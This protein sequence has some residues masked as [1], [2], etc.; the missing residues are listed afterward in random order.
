M[1]SLRLGLMM[2]VVVV[3]A[4]G[5]AHPMTMRADIAG[6]ALPAG[7]TPIPKN[8]GLYISP[9]N[10]AKEVTTPGGGG[11]K[12]SYHPYADMETGLYKI[13]GETFQNVD[14]L[15]TL[16]DVN[17]I[18]KHSLTLIAIP[19]ITTTSSSSGFFTWMATDFTVQLSC[20]FT[21]VAGREVTV[22][23][24]T[25]TGHAEFAELKSDFSVAGERASRDALEKFQAAVL[26]SEAL[27]K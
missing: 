19:E 17:S 23:S 21:D 7:A 3:M 14:V 27:R 22:V 2:A 18:A 1:K 15:S 25:G 11:D 8:V 24:S 20:K 6:L 5:C 13:F 16:S 10:R 4:A 26:Q 12:V 9:D